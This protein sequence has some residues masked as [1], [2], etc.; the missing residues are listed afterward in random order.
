MPEFPSFIGKRGARDKVLRAPMLLA[1][2]VTVALLTAVH[3][4]GDVRYAAVPQVIALSWLGRFLR[5]MVPDADGAMPWPN[6]RQHPLHVCQFQ[7]L[8]P[9]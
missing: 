1:A 2:A 9:P 4:H 8:G 3:F 6:A 5:R 7:K